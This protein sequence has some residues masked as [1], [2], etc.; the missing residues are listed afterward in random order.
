MPEKEWAINKSYNSKS[1][2]TANLWVDLRRKYFD[3]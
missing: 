2:I 1:D 3:S